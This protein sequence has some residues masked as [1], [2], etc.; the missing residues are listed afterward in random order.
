MILLVNLICM[1]KNEREVLMMVCEIIIVCLTLA[2]QVL[3][4]PGLI[5]YI[6]R[7]KQVRR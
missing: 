7:N 4:L 3:V 2:V 6:S 5:M 1:H